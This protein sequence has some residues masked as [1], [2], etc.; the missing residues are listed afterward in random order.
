MTFFEEPNQK[1]YHLQGPMG[2]GTLV[3]MNGE[4]IAFTGGT[5]CLVFLDLVAF[6][7]KLNL[8]IAF[9]SKDFGPDFKFIFYTSFRNKDDSIALDLCNGL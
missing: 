1:I 7:I 2:K 8:G 6:L 9:N 5:G 4:N 3:D